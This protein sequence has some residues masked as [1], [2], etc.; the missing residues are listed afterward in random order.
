MR[1]IGLDPGKLGAVAWLD[2]TLENVGVQECP[3]LL[4]PPKPGKKNPRKEYDLGG[5][6]R[7]LKRVANGAGCVVTL[8]EVG[9]FRTDG[10]TRTF[11]FGTGY[12]AWLAIIAAVNVECGNLVLR[13]VP[14]RTWKSV[15]LAGV[16]NDPKM[17]AKVLEARL[18][19]HPVCSEFKGKFGGIHDGK[20]DALWLAEH[21]RSLYRFPGRLA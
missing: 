12:G 8:E 19:H 5:M 1:F 10:R 2:G 9:A 7:L 3:L 11:D 6:Y 13:L 21:G 15:M 4:K 14:P 20:V 18:H 16:A 17:E